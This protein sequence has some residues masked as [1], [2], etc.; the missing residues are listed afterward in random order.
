[1]V[2]FRYV[3]ASHKDYCEPREKLIDSMID[4]GVSADMME[5]RVALADDTSHYR[6]VPLIPSNHNSFEYTPLI[7]E[8]YE[9]NPRNLFLLHDTC[10][11]FGRFLQQTQCI[12]QFDEYVSVDKY[13]WTNMGYYSSSFLISSKRIILSLKNCDKKRAQYAER[14]FTRLGNW[15]S[16]S[17]NPYTVKNNSCV[18]SSEIQREHIEFDGVDM[19]KYMANHPR[20]KNRILIP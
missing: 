9:S 4:A 18:Y 10:L 8:L 16:F 12:N 17:S 19:I 3:I 5:V 15:R 6:D 14:L 13:G 1:M 7:D 11:V 2:N 20:V